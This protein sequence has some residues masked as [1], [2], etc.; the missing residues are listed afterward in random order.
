[1]KAKGSAGENSTTRIHDIKLK[2]FLKTLL[3]S[4]QSSHLGFLS[5]SSIVWLA[6]INS[7]WRYSFKTRSVRSLWSVIKLP[8]IGAY[9]VP[10]LCQALYIHELF[11]PLNSLTKFCYCPS[12]TD[13]ETEEQT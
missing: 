4:V 9:H 12:S 2:W 11:D 3:Y 10:K 13:E 7:S 8:L 5:Q 1:M 6:A